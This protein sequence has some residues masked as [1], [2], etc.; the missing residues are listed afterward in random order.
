MLFRIPYLLPH[1]IFHHY[2]LRLSF[3]IYKRKKQ[4]TE[5]T[6]ELQKTHQN[7]SHR[8][9]IVIMKRTLGWRHLKDR[10][11]SKT[12]FDLCHDHDCVRHVLVEE[13]LS[14]Y[15]LILIILLFGRSVVKKLTLPRASWPGN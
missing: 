4:L 9:Q 1:C 6:V 8:S 10:Q 15:I 7:K 11:F 12:E 5:F 14:Y 2:L 13:Y 3:H